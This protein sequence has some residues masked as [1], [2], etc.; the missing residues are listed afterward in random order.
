M[1]SNTT[2]QCMINMASRVIKG[3]YSDMVGSEMGG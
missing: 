2:L 3:I 1:T